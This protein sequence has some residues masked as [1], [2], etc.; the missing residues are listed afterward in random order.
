MHPIVDGG[1]PPKRDV[2][3][4]H[5]MGFRAAR[6]ASFAGVLPP[7]VPP[8]DMISKTAGF[9]GHTIGR[10]STGHAQ[11]NRSRHAVSEGKAYQANY[12]VVVLGTPGTDPMSALDPTTNGT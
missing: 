6:L 7:E 9:E 2:V 12:P 3:Q 10:F 8:D 1:D 11:K 5:R 4:H